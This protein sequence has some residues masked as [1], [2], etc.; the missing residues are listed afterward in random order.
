M[1][2]SLPEIRRAEMLR[3]FRASFI[4]FIG[5]LIVTEQVLTKSYLYHFDHWIKNLKHH[6]FK[7]LS[8]H[9]LLALDDMGLRS[10][11]A[12][13][14][15]VLAAFI[16]WRFKSWRPIYLSVSALLLLNGVVGLSKLIF[17]RTKPRLALDLLHAGGLSYPS[18]HSANA[19][20]TWGMCSYLIYRYT[21][22]KPFRGIKLN[23]LVALITI[24]VC[25]VSL[26]RDTHWFS[27]L[28]GGVLIGGSLLVF[29]IAVDR[30]WPS[31]R[32][33]S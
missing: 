24:T 8:S 6:T 14:L 26:I 1:F 16:G 21:N 7:G 4:L 18:G 13:V 29:L 2:N 10:F 32:Q 33:P 15:L 27:D 11:T 25:V 30:A 17:G 23:W 31:T 9:A 5:F 20:L 3:A 12:T 22:R 28:L 19:L